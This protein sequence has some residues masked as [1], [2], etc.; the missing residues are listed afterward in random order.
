MLTS[1][2]QLRRLGLEKLTC[3]KSHLDLEELSLSGKTF[4]DL[5]FGRDYKKKSSPLDI[6]LVMYF[7]LYFDYKTSIKIM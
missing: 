1:I 6:I 5:S 2:L 4:S 3:T 7:A